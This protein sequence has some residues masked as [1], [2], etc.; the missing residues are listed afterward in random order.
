MLN[1]EVLQTTPQTD[2]HLAAGQCLT[3]GLN[4]N[5]EVRDVELR[6]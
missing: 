2:D 6:T 4:L 5:T 1:I 3:E